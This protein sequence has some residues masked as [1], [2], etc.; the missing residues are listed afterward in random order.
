MLRVGKI[1]EHIFEAEPLLREAAMVTF[2]I[3][4]IRYSDAPAQLEPS[5]NGLFGDEACGLARCSRPASAGPMSVMS[6]T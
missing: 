2:N 1:R 6:S 4:A 5:P 3:N